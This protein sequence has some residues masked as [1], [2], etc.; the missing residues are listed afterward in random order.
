MQLAENGLKSDIGGNVDTADQDQIAFPSRGPVPQF[1]SDQRG[2][3]S[4]VHRE[5]G[6]H[7]I[8]AIGDASRV[9][10]GMSVG[11]VSALKMGRLALVFLNCPQLPRSSR[12][13]R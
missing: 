12:R 5:I 1:S 6:P 3:A 7:Q 2:G 8:Q 4:G 9:R 10:F 13:K 11:A